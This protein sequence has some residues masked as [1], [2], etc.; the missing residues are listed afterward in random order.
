MLRVA[1]V[2]LPI[3]APGQVLVR[4]QAAGVNPADT[5]IRSGQYAHLPTLPYTPGLDGAGVVTA[6]GTDVGQVR[7]GERVYIVRSTSGTYAEYAV[8]DAAQVH[9]LPDNVSFV[10]GAAVGIPY[11]TAYRALFLRARALPG[12]TVLVHGA[13]GAVGLAAVQLARA[14]GLRVIATGGSAVGRELVAAQG[15]ALVLDHHAATVGQAVLDATHGRGVDVIVEMLA[16]LNLGRDLPLLASGGRVAVVG[17]RGTVEVN[18]R[19]LMAREAAVF[20]VM[21]WNATAAEA[22][23]SHAALHAGLAAGTLAPVVG[24]Q[25]ALADAAQAHE[26]VLQP[27]ALG[28]LVLVP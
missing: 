22:A 27:G 9:P 21:L 25:F 7:V 15:A 1:D 24:R 6:A 18:P 4:V 19:D 28:K 12:E 14:A 11:T 23:C 20:G 5:Y 8:A 17:N 13:T 3:A 26:R 10:Q 2:D 16:N